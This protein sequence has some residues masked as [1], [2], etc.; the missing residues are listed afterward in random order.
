MSE[1]LNDAEFWLNLMRLTG[2]NMAVEGFAHIE[3]L[4]DSDRLDERTLRR[5]HGALRSLSQ[6]ASSKAAILEG[7]R[8]YPWEF[9]RHT[10]LSQPEG[11]GQ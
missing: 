2:S 9:S 6:K 3:E 5:L 11:T 4:I 1:D 10:T 8:K 7:K